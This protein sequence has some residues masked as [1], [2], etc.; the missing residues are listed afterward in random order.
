M[1]EGGQPSNRRFQFGL[2]GLFVVTTIICFVA[3]SPM[4]AVRF[5]SGLG[6]LFVGAAIMRAA[7]VVR[8]EGWR[9]GAVFGS[10]FVLIGAAGCVLAIILRIYAPQI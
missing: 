9:T 6:A 4:F 5:S 1:D 8:G 7:I 10:F 2:L 3:A